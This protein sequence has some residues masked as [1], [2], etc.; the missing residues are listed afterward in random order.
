MKRLLLT[1]ISLSML[2]FAASCGEAKDSGKG[3]AGSSA[4][5]KQELREFTAE[6]LKEYDGQD[7]NPTYVAIEGKVYDMSDVGAW[8]GGTHKGNS[9]GNDLT[10]A[11]KSK[12]PHGLKVLKG[13]KV[14]GVLV[15]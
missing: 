8:S 5:G 15:E 13:K 4:E 9:A 1:L 12:S 3:E 7:G 10:K 11:I 6:E 2:I 14:V